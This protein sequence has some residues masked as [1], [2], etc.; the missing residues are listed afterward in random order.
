MSGIKLVINAIALTFAVVSGAFS[1]P[2]VRQLNVSTATTNAKTD[3]TRSATQYNK[4]RSTT[5]MMIKAPKTNTAAPVKVASTKPSTQTVRVATS[6]QTQRMTGKPVSIGNNK[7]NGTY[8]EHASTQLMHLKK[9]VN[10]L[11][12]EV[13]TKTNA[14]Q[15]SD[16]ITTATQGMITAGDSFNT[17]L[18]GTTLY[19]TV[20]NETTGLVIKTQTLENAFDKDTDGA[21]TNV[22]VDYVPANMPME[23]ISGLPTL[24]Q[25]TTTLAGKF[26]TD[27]S[28]NITNLKETVVPESIARKEFV[29]GLKFKVD[30]DE[31]IKFS[32]DNTNWGDVA[33]IGEIGTEGPAG[34]SAYDI[35]L[36]NGGEGDKTVF[37]DSLKGCSPT[38]TSTDEPDNRRVKVEI[39]GCGNETQTEYVKY[40]ED[41]D[42]KTPLITVEDGKIKYYYNG[43]E[44]DKHDIIALNDLKG[45]TPT[46]TSTDD[47]ENRRVKVEFSGCGT[48]TQTEYLPYGKDGG[49]ACELTYETVAGTGT[50]GGEERNGYYLKGRCA[51]D[52][53]GT[54]RV[55]Q[56]IPNG[57]D[58][59][60]QSC[61]SG[62]IVDAGIAQDP[63][64]ES[65]CLRNYKILCGSDEKIF[66]GDC[67]GQCIDGQLVDADITADNKLKKV[68]CGG[69]EEEEPLPG[70]T[71]CVEGEIIDAGIAQ[72]PDKEGV[73]LRNYKVLCGSEEK[74]F[75]GDCTGQCIDGQLVD[76]DI[77]ADNKLKK[78]YCGGE[79]EEDPL[80]EPE[81]VP[82]YDIALDETEGYN[83]LRH[84]KTDCDGNT[85]FGGPCLGKCVNGQ[86]TEVS[87]KDN[88]LLKKYCGGDEEEE[89]LPGGTTCVEGEIIDTGIAQDPDKEGTCLRNYKILCGSEEKIF[90]GDCT[91]QCI[92]GQLI[93]AD[94]TADNK[95]K[96]VYCGGEEEEDPLPEPECVPS[97]IEIYDE[98]DHCYKLQTKDCDGN[99]T[100]GQCLY[101]TCKNKEIVSVAIVNN[102]LRETYCDDTH[103]D[104]DLPTCQE[105]DV[106]GLTVANGKI[107]KALCGGGSSEET[108]PANTTCKEGDIEKFFF[109]DSG[110]LKVT[111]CD[112]SN[113]ETLTTPYEKKSALKNLAYKN[114]VGSD[115]ING[116]L[117]ASKVD[118]SGYQTKITS[119]NPLDSGSVSFST[120]QQGVFNS[121]VTA[122]HISTLGS[123]DALVNGDCKDSS[124]SKCNPGLE[125]YET[126]IE[127]LLTGLQTNGVV[128]SFDI[129]T[130]V[131][132][133]PVSGQC[134]SH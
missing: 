79:E 31:K 44:S 40:G 119:S 18:A 64:K 42:G 87:I 120:A 23:K 127:N 22:K 17:E 81:C 94:I 90:Y 126:L 55:N 86:L 116:T 46:V 85:S 50:I 49:D 124:S 43:E 4:A 38:I 74:I 129:K 37:L 39:S 19:N 78:V 16:A 35:W 67:T 56:F 27:E 24:N 117:P 82:E 105:G 73:C 92:D 112:Q 58:G 52:P 69:N 61:E 103:E 51:S 113:S 5:P 14:Q 110:N 47:P 107:T 32:F 97:S 21:I 6:D 41:G 65:T 131:V 130:G 66:Y 20:N 100:T 26:D 13:D 53:E 132:N 111:Y 62:Q 104:K 96:K 95:L 84:R 60:G 93:D 28:G 2:S 115:D 106:V 33:D 88:K 45:C 48:E 25:K 29:T 98:T 134:P 10:V 71:T 59:L 122:T 57:K 108:L 128:C 125:G 121:G 83:C 8:V 54:Y 72:D 7:L 15:V 80:P 12:D 118:L 70:D 89:P 101:K 3:S 102:K 68:Y 9:D 30:S 77:T 75:Y 99:V 36:E 11:S 63:T 1:A 133:V 109:D 76:A 34:A 123:L 114:T 91:G